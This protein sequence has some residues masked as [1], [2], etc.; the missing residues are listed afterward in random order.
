MLF[1]DNDELHKKLVRSVLRALRLGGHDDVADDFER[2]HPE[3]LEDA[4]PKYI[5]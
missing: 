3:V 4:P 1:E 2:E 5:M